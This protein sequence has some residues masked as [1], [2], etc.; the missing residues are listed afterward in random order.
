[1][2]KIRTYF[3]VKKHLPKNDSYFRDH[4]VQPPLYDFA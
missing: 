2:T 3:M 1:M 4:V